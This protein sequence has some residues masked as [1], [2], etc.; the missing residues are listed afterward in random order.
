MK[1][2]VRDGLELLGVEVGVDPLV[3]EVAE[4]VRPVD[5]NAG[6]GL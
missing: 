1:R 2:L 4:L 3:E 6:A 5:Q